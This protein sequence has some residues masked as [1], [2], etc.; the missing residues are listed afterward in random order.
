VNFPNLARL[1]RDSR[2]TTT[3]QWYSAVP[4]PSQLL[5]NV[6]RHYR[7]CEETIAIQSQGKAP[8]T[9]EC[10]RDGTPQDRRAQ[11]TP[12]PP[13]TDILAVRAAVGDG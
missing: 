12:E 13:R 2:D 5:P 4:L 1:Q 11:I 8:G 3:V 9:V 10:Q 6:K 7:A